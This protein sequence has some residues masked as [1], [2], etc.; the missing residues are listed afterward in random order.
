MPTSRFKL[1]VLAAVVMFSSDQAFA[2]AAEAGAGK[3]LNV[4]LIMAD[5]LN[6]R[7]GCYGDPQVKSPNIDRLAARGVR[8]DRTYCQYPLCNPS[9]ASFLTGLRPS[10]TGVIDNAVQFRQ[11]I[12]DVVTLPQLFRNHGYFVARVGKLY[13][14]GVPNQI[15]TSGLDDPPSWEKVVNPRGRDKDDEDKIITIANHRNFGGTLS[16]L[17]ADG[18]DEEQ[19]DGVGAAAAVKI[20]EERAAVEQPFFLGVGFYRPHTPY[21]APKKYHEL[22]P[23]DKIPLATGPDNDREDVPKAAFTVNPPNYGLSPERQREA[24]QAYFAATSFMD[25]QVG[26]LLDALDRLKLTDKTVVVFV[27]DHGYHLG[28]HGQWQKLSLFEGSTRVPLVIATPS[29]KNAGQTS[30]RLVEMIDVYPTLAELCGLLAPQ[31]LHGRSLNPLLDDVAAEHKSA[32]Y[33][34]ARNGYSVRT[35][36]FR[37]TEWTGANGGAELYDHMA[38]PNEFTNLATDPAHAETVK[39]MRE[40]LQKVPPAPLPPPK[41]DAGKQKAKTKTS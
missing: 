14:Y 4:L 25:A 15:G 20:L 35:D 12:P 22:Y 18:T 19:T 6:C 16:W 23:R 2:A 37:Y 21:V 39:Q 27:S 5:D 38:D 31:N 17:A 9:R 34:Q 33:T 26:K 36:R 41:P 10:G 8:F 30:Q 32:A 7:L 13:H 11:N 1:H 29:M 40:Q 24:I 3:K 28:E